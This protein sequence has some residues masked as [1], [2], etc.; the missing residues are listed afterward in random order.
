M[1]FR[2]TNCVSE[3]PIIVNGWFV[4]FMH[5]LSFSKFLLILFVNR[6]ECF[7]IFISKCLTEFSRGQIITFRNI[8]SYFIK[9]FIFSVIL[10]YCI[11]I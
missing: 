9:F 3:R 11:E 5:S 4:D 2:K 8:I 1:L 6:E 10:K 7:I